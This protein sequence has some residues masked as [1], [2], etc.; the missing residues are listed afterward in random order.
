VWQQ[1]QLLLSG[2]CAA[3]CAFQVRPRWA[4]S[5]TACLLCCLALLLLLSVL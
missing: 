5:L 3:V 2:A 1:Q 4:T